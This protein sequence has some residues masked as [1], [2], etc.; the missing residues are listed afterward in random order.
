MGAVVNNVNN[1]VSGCMRKGELLVLL[2]DTSREIL[3]HGN[4]SP[5]K[6]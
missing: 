2:N 3:L 5:R 4:N 6:L 1:Y